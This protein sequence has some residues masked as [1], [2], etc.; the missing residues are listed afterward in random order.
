MNSKHLQQ[1]LILLVIFLVCSITPA[2]AT[3]NSDIQSN[4]DNISL[5]NE[6][7]IEDM[8][9]LLNSFD[10]A[11]NTELTPEQDKY[12]ETHEPILLSKAE[13][14]LYNLQQFLNILLM[15]YYLE[16]TT[17]HNENKRNNEN[18]LDTYNATELWCT[19]E[20]LNK[21]IGR[22]PRNTN[23]TVKFNN[24][25]AIIHV[26]DPQYGYMESVGLISIN[27]NKD[28]TNSDIKYQKAKNNISCTWA[29]FTRIY[30]PTKGK[31]KDMYSI[32]TFNCSTQE[33]LTTIYT[34]KYLAL[35]NK[36]ERLDNYKTI[37]TIFAGAGG[38]AVAVAG[39][40]RLCDYCNGQTR[41]R[42]IEIIEHPEE[43]APLVQPNGLVK[44][45]TRITEEVHNNQHCNKCTVGV[46]IVTCGT[47]I[48]IGSVI[49]FIICIEESIKCKNK[50]KCL[51]EYIQDDTN[52]K[53]IHIINGF[54][55]GFQY[56]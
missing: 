53:Y 37:C 27:K 10:E 20:D 23:K 21:G 22:D 35:D 6:T 39:A 32:T 1:F 4:S 25:R 42:I 51:K 18:I 15:E 13:T 44:R 52:E 36:K 14:I 46:G 19:L 54:Y 17:T 29:D 43:A 3:Q 5:F 28:N 48:L 40:Y 33:V 31:N 11:S 9:K 30:Q 45:Y 50:L 26:K 16:N 47:L 8:T 24:S 7:Y 49:G 41:Q 55:N 38:I 56:F 34:K 2:S 12:L